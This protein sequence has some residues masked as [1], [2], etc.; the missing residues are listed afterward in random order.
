MMM[1]TEPTPRPTPRAILSEVLSTTP[2]LPG[3]PVGEAPSVTVDWIVTLVLGVT[4]L[5]E[6]EEDGAVDRSRG[7]QAQK[8]ISCQGGLRTSAATANASAAVSIGRDPLVGELEPAPV[9]VVTATTV[10][11]GEEESS[12]V[13]ATLAFGTL[14]R[15]Q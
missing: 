11:V 7:A 12:V 4:V 13:S 9:T 6:V 14:L 10:V 3:P 1:V 5:V 2:F 15:E 8:E